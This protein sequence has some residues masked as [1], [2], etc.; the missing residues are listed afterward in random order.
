MPVMRS[1]VNWR[2]FQMVWWSIW[3][4]KIFQAV[5]CPTQLFQSKPIRTFNQHCLSYKISNRLQFNSSL[6]FWKLFET[7]FA[8][9][10]IQDV[11]QIQKTFKYIKS[12]TYNYL[13]WA[14]IEGT[15]VIVYQI[16]APLWYKTTCGEIESRKGKSHITLNPFRRCLPWGAK[17][18]FL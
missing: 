10:R 3:L 2:F 17:Y 16:N 5:L 1:I 9:T 13:L 14:I 18:I 8:L 6:F 12:D 4:R 15:L 7:V 11:P